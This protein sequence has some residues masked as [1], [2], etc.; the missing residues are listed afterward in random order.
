MEIENRQDIIEGRNPVIEAIKSGRSINK[1]LVAK[2]EK[3]GS[4]NYLIALAKERKIVI[5]NVDRIKLDSVSETGK[6]QGVIA[7]VSAKE[8]VEVDD[9]LR[10]ANEKNED[11]FIIILDGI[12]DAQNLGAILRTAD[13]TGVHG[14]I[15]PKR[16]AI[17]LTAAVARISAGAYEYVPVARVVNIARTIDYFKKKNIWVVGTDSLGEKH[18][19]ESDLKGA[20]AI[21][22]GSEGEGM[23]RLVSEKCDFVVNIPMKGYINSLNSSVSAALVMYEVLR[24][25]NM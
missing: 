14:V 23:S 3:E 8:Y 25:R 9:I 17:G 15:I 2:G 6:H 21:V 12:G 7:Y 18:Y 24:Q 16:R 5:Q 19:Q 11:P 13:A 1:I 22:V 20:I 10:I 4:I